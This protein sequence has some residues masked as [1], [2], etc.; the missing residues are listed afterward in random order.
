MFTYLFCSSGSAVHCEMKV[1]PNT[2][3]LWCINDIYFADIYCV[4]AENWQIKSDAFACF[5]KG[6]LGC[7]WSLF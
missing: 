3:L 2:A 4:Y 6:C 7:K 5:K 1:Y